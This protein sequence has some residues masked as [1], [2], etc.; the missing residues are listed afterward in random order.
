MFNHDTFKAIVLEE[1]KNTMK[2]NMYT[3]H[4]ILNS[5]LPDKLT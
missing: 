3:Y 1:L 4:K 2:T 5:Q